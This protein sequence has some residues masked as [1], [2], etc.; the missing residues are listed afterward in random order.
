M[1][2]P[3]VAVIAI[4]GVGDHEADATS[5]LLAAQL[6]HFYPA[7]FTAFEC[8][9]L[10]IAVDTASLPIPAREQPADAAHG[11][12]L[13]D[14]VRARAISAIP[15][16]ANDSADIAFTGMTLAG[17]EDHKAS[18][19][20][21]RL[22]CDVRG[23]GGIDLYEM[24]WSDLSHG[25][26]KGGLRMLRE[27]LQLFLHIACLGRT[28][29][30]TLLA[31]LGQ[32]AAVPG[33]SQAYIASACGYWLLAVPIALGNLLLLCFGAAFLGLLVPEND[34]GRAG[35]AIGAAILAATLLGIAWRRMMRNEHTPPFLERFGLP[36]I[37]LVTVSVPA[38]GI[39]WYSKS[40]IPASNVAFALAL[41]I[42]LAAGTVITRRYEASRP[43]AMF[44]WC[45]IVGFCV[46]CGIGGAAI[47]LW[48]HTP[49][50]W[51]D[52]LAFAV[53]G[54]FACLVAMCLLLVLNNLW[55]LA[56]GERAKHYDRPDEA[57]RRAVDTCL[58][59]AA[60]PASLL[61]IVVLTLW[62]GA[63]NLLDQGHFSLM[64]K[65]VVLPYFGS[66]T[67]SELIDKFIDLSASPAAVPFLLCMAVALTGVVV[68]I[69]LPVLAELLPPRAPRDD[70]R[71]RALWRWLDQ[72]LGLLHF[73]KWFAVLGFFAVLPAGAVAQYFAGSDWSLASAGA[74]IGVGALA[75]VSVTR[76]FG[77]ISLS[78][79]SRTFARMRVVIDTA[80]DVDNWLRERPVG[81][82]PR[83]RIMARYVS[84][85]RHLQQQGY[86][87]I[88]VVGHSQG[89]VITVDLLRY[90]KAQKAPLLKQLGPIDLLTFGSPLRQLYAARFPALYGWVV[91]LAHDQ[92]RRQAR[93]CSWTNGYGSGD[94]VGR[95]LWSNDT[96]AQPWQP[97]R[98]D[99]PDE[100]C[101][102]AL[103]HTHYFDEHAPDVAAA[104][105]NAITAA[106]ASVRPAPLPQCACA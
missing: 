34:A 70:A 10:H 71:S 21:T 44:A 56:A 36:L 42:A 84:L 75:F 4:H 9:P 93:L 64:D 31:S 5:A 77:K 48:N 24:F 86:K 3:K 59:A 61:L 66:P 41:P 60:V 80:I 54:N 16:Q 100:F 25:G 32:Q 81:Q 40:S 12:R 74:T 23:H 94:Y 88:V 63:K 33:L 101:T 106:L 22:R 37:W 102:G 53:T 79:V 20:T 87:R 30:S 92:A 105:R 57:V 28:A 38:L 78:T 68:G 49:L 91:N 65:H 1:D 39:L 98:T 26:T 58:V 95:N 27:M 82:T 50:R 45:F 2:K 76:L 69:V 62:L 89:T 11:G 55:L 83:L 51:L 85:L 67:V 103:A 7:E 97:G 19:T 104:I 99:D 46:L 17:G 52:V 73:G 96:T 13:P 72:G 29:L 90:L 6:Q 18:Y 8:A 15:Q 14:S 35:T 47:F 43:G